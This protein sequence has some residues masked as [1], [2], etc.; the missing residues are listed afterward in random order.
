MEQ[1]TATTTVESITELT[2]GDIVSVSG[3]GVDVTSHVATID[4]NADKER[5]VAWLEPDGVTLKLR[6]T[7]HPLQTDGITS[8]CGSVTVE[9]HL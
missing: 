3:N 2:E 9:R 1:Q 6:D 4:Y 7:D 5:M 8:N